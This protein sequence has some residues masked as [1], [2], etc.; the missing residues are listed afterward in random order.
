M[1]SHSEEL[2]TALVLDAY[3]AGFFPMASERDGP[4]TWHSPDP[5]AIIPL[6]SFHIPR[7]LRQV[8]RTGTFVIRVDSCFEEVIRA[9]ADRGETWISAEIIRTYIRLREEGFGHSVEV[10]KDGILAGGLYGVAIGGAFFGES[11]FSRVPNASKVALVALVDLLTTGG[12]VLLDTQYLTPHLEQFG[13]CE[14]G[15]PEYLTLL[16]EAVLRDARLPQSTDC[17]TARRNAPSL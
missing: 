12:F 7:S 6:R 17:L 5:R 16:E 11:M 4:I 13:A 14:I 1:R 2:S 3:R 8:I 9:C 15:R 10:W